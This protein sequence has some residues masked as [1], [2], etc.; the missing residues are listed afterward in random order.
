[1]TGLSMAYLSISS[2]C[3]D[4][5]HVRLL[6]T[7]N[8]AKEIFVTM[9]GWA[10]KHTFKSIRKFVSSFSCTKHVPGYMLGNRTYALTAR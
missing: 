10:P 3:F 2:I 6:L 7:C 5:S 9:L 8:S 4:A 1:M